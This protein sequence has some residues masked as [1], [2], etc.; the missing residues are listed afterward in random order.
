MADP[1]ARVPADACVRFACLS[2]GRSA[3]E[4]LAVI[5]G[6]FD[7]APPGATMLLRCEECLEAEAAEVLS[8]RQA[9]AGD[10]SES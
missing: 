3:T 7:A 9:P 2:C 8:R 1:I 10:G 5:V 6:F 4:A